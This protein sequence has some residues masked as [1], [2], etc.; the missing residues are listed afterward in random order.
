MLPGA[1]GQEE[2]GKKEEREGRR[3]REGRPDNAQRRRCRKKL[4]VRG[5][6]KMDRRGG[7]EG[8]FGK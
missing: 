5:R 8:V 3:R 7:D 6:K 4:K 2:M 1:R